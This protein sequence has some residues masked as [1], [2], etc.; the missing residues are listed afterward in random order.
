M[1]EDDN[2]H[3]FSAAERKHRLCIVLQFLFSKN[4]TEMAP[5]PEQQAREWY[6]SQ[7]WRQGAN[8][9]PSTAANQIEMWQNFDEETIQR[10]LSWVS[11]IG[12]NAVRVF[13][14]DLVW[15]HEKEDFFDKVDRFL[16]LADGLG[17][18]TIL[19]LLEG[20]WDPVPTYTE[21]QSQ[22]PPR[23]A[24][25]NS[26]WLQSPGRHVLENK[27]LHESYLRLYVEQVIGRF[28]N[29]TRVLMLDLFDQPENDNR[30]SY[31]SYGNR[32]EV[33]QDALGTEMSGDLKAQLIKE[34]VPRLLNWVWSLGP[35]S[36]P[37]TIP[38]W[39]AVDDNDDSNYGKI[40]G[41]LRHL[42]LNSS[43]II[44][45]HNYANLTQL[46]NVLGEIRDVY[47]GRPVALSSF[48]ARESHSTLDP[49][50]QRMY[51]ENVWALHWGF[52]AG[53]I[54]TIY[55]SD[56]WNIEYSVKKE[57][58]P[59]HHDL[60]RPNGTFYSKSEQAYLSSFRSS[61]PTYRIGETGW[62]S[63]SV[64]ALAGCLLVLL[65]V[66]LLLRNKFPLI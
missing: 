21:N 58:L 56:S 22:L 16:T 43:D 46:L 64:T 18:R 2:G 53:K 60:L 5:W 48:M 30:K 47:P 28:G 52:V 65:T 45:F 13:L 66:L 32:V 40:Q 33:C 37:F 35:R 1:F 61:L 4:R 38:A 49:I 42:Y 51:Q 8:F 29:D 17:I 39:T 63:V 55:P 24:V 34:L 50:L 9:I 11:R 31:G 27:T 12:Y 36:V 3:R 54:Q 44:T 19:V 20:I 10:E 6:E 25:H 59:W 26:R 15:K 62:D 14:H 57:P 7:G 23:P 41:E